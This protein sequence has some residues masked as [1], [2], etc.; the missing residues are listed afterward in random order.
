MAQARQD[1]NP[2]DPEN[3]TVKRKRG[4]PRKDEALGSEPSKRIR[5][6][7]IDGESHGADPAIGQVVSGVLDGRFDAGYMLTVQVGGRGRLLRGL[8]FEPGCSVPVSSAN[9]VAPDV[10]MFERS[11]VSMPSLSSTGRSA[12]K[13]DG[14]GH[15]EAKALVGDLNHPVDQTGC[16]N[17]GRVMEQAAS[18]EPASK[19]RSDCETKLN[20]EDKI[21]Q[22]VAA[23]DPKSIAEGANPQQIKSVESSEISDSGEE[24]IG[25]KI[26]HPTS[27]IEESKTQQIIKPLEFSI[28][29]DSDKDLSGSKVSSTEEA[30]KLHINFTSGDELGQSKVSGPTSF[31]EEAE[32]MQIKPLES[33]DQ[34]TLIMSSE[35]SAVHLHEEQAA[36]EEQALEQI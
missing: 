27:S 18:D 33:A 9:D 19:A 6:P 30:E 1:D 32:N 23:S 22:S 13:R 21:L 2:V 26:S 5:R 8:V 36:S 11:N 10:K 7:R 28:I 4:R 12:F 34:S 15:N 20:P 29:S 24:L 25:P 17:L 31:N 3:H 14:P 16:R 35:I